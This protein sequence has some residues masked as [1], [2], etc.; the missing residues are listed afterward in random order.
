MEKLSTAAK[1]NY[2]EVFTK[3]CTASLH[4]LV[5]LNSNF[6]SQILCMDHTSIK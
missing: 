2:K 5:L 3:Q 4:K 1:A 6:K